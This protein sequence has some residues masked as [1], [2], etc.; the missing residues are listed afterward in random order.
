MLDDHFNVWLLEVNPS[1]SMDP[2]GSTCI[3][4][5]IHNVQTDLANIVIDNKASKYTDTGAFALVHKAKHEAS[6]RPVKAGQ[7]VN[8]DVI[9]LQAGTKMVS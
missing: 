9:G 2:K 8:F 5:M 3:K 4:D 1:P 7:K 6:V